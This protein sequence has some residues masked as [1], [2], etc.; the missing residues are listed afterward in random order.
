MDV[1]EIC[2]LPHDPSR[3][4]FVFGKREDINLIVLNNVIKRINE[5]KKLTK[6]ISCDCKWK[7]DGRKYNSNQKWNN[8]I[9]RFEC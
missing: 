4:I 5:Q 8:S 1:M 9:C 2:N 3:R 7:F 6:H